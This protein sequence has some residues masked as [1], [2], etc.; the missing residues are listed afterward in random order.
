MTR[1]SPLRQDIIRSARAL[2]Y[3]RARQV[4]LEHEEAQLSETIERHKSQLERVEDVWR[5]VDYL[6]K[7]KPGSAAASSLDIVTKMFVKMKVCGHFISFF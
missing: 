7:H 4:T 6:E 3:E 5:A 1:A 2:R